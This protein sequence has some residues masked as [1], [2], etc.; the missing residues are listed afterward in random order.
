MPISDAHPRDHGLLDRLGALDLHG[1]LRVLEP[2]GESL[3][4]RIPG[5]R[6]ALAHNERL[7]GQLCHGD[8]AFR[9]ERMRRCRD[10]DIGM[11][12]ERLGR[13]VHIDRR[14]DHDR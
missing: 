11:G 7:V 9:R 10:D 5:V 12:R 8:E 3:L 6:A 14:A 4:H 1:H 2:A 13:D